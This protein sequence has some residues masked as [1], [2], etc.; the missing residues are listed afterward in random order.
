[1]KPINDNDI[2]KLESLIKSKKDYRLSFLFRF[3][4]YRTL[5]IF[6][7]PQRE[8]EITTKFFQEITDCIYDEREDDKDFSTF[9]LLI[10][11][12]QT[13]YINK[14]GEKYYLI[15]TIRGH[16]LFN[17]INYIKRYLNYCINEE[18]EKSKK[19]SKI[20]ISDKA[21]QD[22]VFATMLPFCNY[23]NEFGVS[24]P[25]LLEIIDSVCKE[26]KLSEDLRNNIN[27]IIG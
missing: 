7:M 26:Y 19:K 2:N 3:N 15:K 24:K 21:K 11:L 25:V 13:F 6:D 4:F 22:I 23:M 8:F 14:D 27:M 20:E 5:G 16:K 9:K 10:I 12:S 18:I 1:M 17:D